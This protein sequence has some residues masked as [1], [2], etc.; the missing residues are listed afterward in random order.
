M[1]QIKYY[2]DP[3][4]AA[5]IVGEFENVAEFLLS[6]FNTYE[7]ILDLRFFD[8]EILG[9]EIVTVGGEFLEINE[10]VV[11]ITHD[12]MLPRGPLVIA[13]AVFAVVLVATILLVPKLPQING[14]NQ[15]QQSATNRLGE[16]T[17][18]P[19]ING[20]IDDIFG[21]VNK[22]TP[23]LWQVPYRIGVDNQE[24]EV[25]FLCVGRGKYQIDTSKWYDGD[26]PVINIAGASVNI[27]EPGSHPGNGSP[28]QTIGT[29][30]DE[31]IGVYR[32]SNDLNPSELIPQ[33]DLETSGIQWRLKKTGSYFEMKAITIPEGFDFME[34]FTVGDSL[35]LADLYHYTISG[36]YEVYPWDEPGSTGLV[37]SLTSEPVNLTADSLLSYEIQS[38]GIDYILLIV[39]AGISAP[40]LAI[41]DSLTS[42][43]TV[44][45]LIINLTTVEGLDIWTTDSRLLA[46][47]WFDRVTTPGVGSGHR[48]DLI[49]VLQQD[50]R[51][52]T[53][54]EIDPEVGPFFI[55]AG[56]TEVILNFVSSSGYYKLVN[57]NETKI[58]SIIRV[59][60]T[61]VDTDG[62]ETG[63]TPVTHNINYSSND[64]IRQSVFQTVRLTLPFTRCKVSA[65]R[66]SD[67]DKREN[68]SNVDVIEWRDMYSFEPITVSDFG[69]VTTAQV[70]VPSNSQSRLIKNRKQNVDLTRKVTQ[71][72]GAGIFGAPESYA[73]DLFDQI[74]IH[75]MLDPYIGRM[76]LENISADAFIQR[77]EEITSYF[78][79]G[80]MV[81]F[82]Y[83]FDTTEMT[84][85][86]TF[87]TICETVMCLP[88]VQLGVYD[89]FFEKAQTVSSMQITCRNKLPGT[90]VRRTN[91]DRKHDGVE[92]TYRSNVTGTADTI[93]IPA[94]RSSLN[95]IRKEL[96][97]CTTALQAYRYGARVYN[98]QVHQ[99]EF[100]KFDVDEFGR[101]II[102]GKRLDSPD[103]TRFTKRQDTTDGY[104]VFDGEVIEVNGLT[105]ELSEPVELVEGEDHYIIF[106]R[107]DGSNS[108]AII[109]T[110]VDKYRVLL[111]VL[112][113]EPIYDGY[114][115]DRTKFTLM[116]EQ[117]THSVALLPQT[118]ESVISDDGSEVI[119]V[120]ATNYSADFYKNDL[121][122]LPE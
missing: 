93:Y 39:P 8:S 36:D 4:K 28:A 11:A 64:N 105:V 79:S 34:Y 112:P 73:T 61:E 119:T 3:T 12:S 47:E 116:S 13:V 31:P 45:S 67:R 62:D 88:Y 56:A 29:L 77:R 58:H 26:T 23:T 81:K 54:S 84:A 19:R 18:E 74:L 60:F 16:S 40:V 20:R 65:E 2:A 57:N 9:H 97:G 42:Y 63:A 101:N 5:E 90:E 44:P 98:K 43:Y 17:N 25:M 37:I 83:D 85:Q 82:G 24:I 7:E 48:Y 15:N 32:Q 87:V 55:P 1:V 76:A 69:D 96:R 113:S 104:K 75:A 115:Q 59:K 35:K 21:T 78:G 27:Y 6:Q 50:L 89:C 99:T 106:T 114:S 51:P 14:V 68:V 103:G 117:L 122:P 110:L 91:Y 107:E 95:P 111:S 94:D 102:P 72:I 66:L 46:G 30:I 52:S 22:H 71:Y 10:G 41:W 86:D 33:N 109:C 108:E 49:T 92:V 120:S 80:D 53:G 70:L 100:V 121:S 118:I 38:V